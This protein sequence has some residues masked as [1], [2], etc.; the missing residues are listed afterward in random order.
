MIPI[1]FGISRSKV[2]VLNNLKPIKLRETIFGVLF[3]HG[4]HMIP[5]DVGV[6]RSKV[7]VMVIWSIKSLFAQ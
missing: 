3:G 1:D 4:R 6:S 2:K 5:I 7:K